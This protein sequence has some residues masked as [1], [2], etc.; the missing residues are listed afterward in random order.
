MASLR[1]IPIRRKLTLITMLTSSTALLLACTA[2]LGYETLTFRRALRQEQSTLADV[3]GANS[4]AAVIFND[5]SAAAKTLSALQ[6]ESHV[7]AA[8][9]YTLDG[10]PFTTYVRADIRRWLPPKPLYDGTS[11][12]QDHLTLYQ[13][14]VHNGERIGTIYLESDL[15]AMRERLARYL[16]ITGLV[17]FASLFVALVLSGRLQRLVSGPILHLVETAHTISETKDYSSRATKAS[18]DELGLLVD[19]FNE[20]LEQIQ[21]RDEGLRQRNEALQAEIIERQAAEEK[22]KAFAAKLEQSNRELQDFAYVAS[23]D[24]QEPLRKIQAFG[25]RLKSKHGDVLTTEGSGYLERMQNAAHRM[26]LLINDLLQFSRITTNAQPFK[27][28]DL[29]KVAREVL[30]DLEARLEQTAGRVQIDELPTID[31]D[32]LQMRQLLQNLIGNA[33]KFHRKDIPPIVQVRWHR[34]GNADRYCEVFVEDNGIGFDEKYLDRIFGVFQRLHGRGEYEG[35]GV[36]L[37]ICRKIVARH[38]GSIT[39]KSKPGQGTTFI[40]TLPVHQPTNRGT[41]HE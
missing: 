18:S 34:N 25:D 11:I 20:M 9:I 28:V 13:P 8:C 39:A 41:N 40:V 35:T 4:A 30:S 15:Q 29:G 23:H 12:E 14:I 10:E 19:S 36:G 26:Q 17:L 27:P 6:A 21:E 32:P 1:D 3:I 37:A 22:L 5:A 2:F 33:L 24:L 38:S 31:A 7:V 16:T